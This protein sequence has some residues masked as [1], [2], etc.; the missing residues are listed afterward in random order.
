MA[1]KS[2]SLALDHPEEV[3][4]KPRILNTPIYNDLDEYTGGSIPGSKHP[5]R[6]SFFNKDSSPNKDIKLVKN[7]KNIDQLSLFDQP[8][9]NFVDRSDNPDMKLVGNKNIRF[10]RGKSAS[11]GQLSLFDQDP[12]ADRDNQI[13]LD[14]GYI[15]DLVDIGDLEGINT[16]D[17]VDI[18]NL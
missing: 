6:Q 4:M 15:P 10:R 7:P 16:D 12:K 11:D 5:K 8:D 9:S 17:L 18:G 14:I 13:R 2:S 3:H 1:D